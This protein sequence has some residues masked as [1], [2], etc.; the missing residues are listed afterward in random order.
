MAKRIALVFLVL[1]LALTAASCGTT[2]SSTTPTGFPCTQFNFDG[3]WGCF[4]FISN[5]SALTRMATSI[6][7]SITRPSSA[8][9]KPAIIMSIIHPATLIVI[10]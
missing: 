5:G 7:I 9:I 8:K 4:Y 10:S 6:I 3:D 1:A 2:V